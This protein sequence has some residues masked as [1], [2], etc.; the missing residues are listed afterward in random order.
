MSGHLLFFQHP[1]L[2]FPG[3]AQGHHTTTHQG[4]SG[5]TAT[6]KDPLAMMELLVPARR[7]YRF[8]ISLLQATAMVHWSGF[9][10]LYTREFEFRN[11]PSAR[12]AEARTL[13]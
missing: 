9:F 6:A 12:P 8:H 1:H 10:N 4:L 13:S 3:G 5:A 2:G 11:T 7:S